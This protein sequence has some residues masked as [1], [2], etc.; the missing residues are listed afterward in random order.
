LTLP[1]VSI[2]IINY[3]GKNLLVNC[4]ESLSKITYSNVEIILVDNNSSDD[5]VE[6]VKE[7]FSKTI[8]IKLDDNKGFAEPNNIGA[9]IAKGKYILFLN[10]DTIVTPNFI[11]EM[12]DVIEKDE[13]I[14]ICQSLLLRPNGDIDSSGDFIDEL[15]VVYNSKSKINDIREISSARGASMLIRKNIFNKL[16]G[17]DES[18]FVSFEDVD[19]GWR[20][21]IANYKVIIIPS[22]IVYHLGGQTS[23]KIK[24][25]IAFHG[26][27]NQL[28]M[29]ITNFET[30][31][32][33]KV[34][35]KFLIIYGIREI[36]IWFDYFLKGDT[37]MTP[38]TYETNIA[39]QPSFKIILKSTLWIF[40]N[41]NYLRKKHKLV[42]STRLISTDQLKKLNIIS[43]SLR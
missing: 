2:I 36:K 26:F 11:T 35:F 12:I 6:Y 43:N 32:G 24:N 23:N 10:N 4:F 7:N 19:L 13:K 29:K 5:S 27:K 34:L 28:S 9:K 16:N 18:F 25:E 33:I 40:S 37:T 17:F 20:S 42:N 3:N 38:T 21:W 39:N 30:I 1:L 14:G 22:S 31:L 8:I 15:G 41:L